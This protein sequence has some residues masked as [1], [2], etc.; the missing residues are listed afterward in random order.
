MCGPSPWNGLSIQEQS[1]GQYVVRSGE[2]WEAWSATLPAD[3]LDAASTAFSLASVGSLPLTPASVSSNSPIVTAELRGP[4]SYESSIVGRAPSK[5]RVLYTCNGD[6]SAEITMRFVRLSMKDSK[7]VLEFKW[8]KFCGVR[9]HTGLAVILPDEKNNI[10]NGVHVIENGIPT[11]I[12]AD[13]HDNQQAKYGV[14][15]KSKFTSFV[16]KI[17]EGM[18]LIQAPILTY[19]SSVLNADATSTWAHTRKPR[20]AAKSHHSMT[21]HYYC[22]R[23]GSSKIMVTL[24]VEGSKHTDFVFTKHCVKPLVKVAPALTVREAAVG[25]VFLLM[26]A[27]IAWTKFKLHKVDQLEREGRKTRDV[28]SGNVVIELAE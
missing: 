17:D 14:G 5:L 28:E 2:L 11:E 10:R 16:V 7:D 8:K 23:E 1:S 9:P 3:G 25:M 6:G 21:V 4:L 19:D 20:E 15:T 18:K 12:F 24:Q 22:L 13:T 27:W 26:F